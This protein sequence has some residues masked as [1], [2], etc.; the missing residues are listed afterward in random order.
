MAS[1]NIWPLSRLNPKRHDCL[2]LKGYRSHFVEPGTV[3]AHGGPVEA[4]RKLLED[5]ANS[6]EWQEYL[7]SSRQTS[8]F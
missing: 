8:L 2:S 6:A 4:T 7:S 1:L 3:A 5:A